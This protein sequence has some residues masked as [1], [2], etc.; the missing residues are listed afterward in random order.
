MMPM[1]REIT[2]RASIPQIM[3]AIRTGGDGM[4]VTFDVPE[5]DMPQA[6]HLVAMRSMVLTVTVKAGDEIEAKAKKERKEAKA[7]G[8]YGA[9]W[10]SLF[11]AGFIS[12]P[13]IQ[14]VIGL[15]RERGD[16][17]ELDDKAMLHAM[18]EVDSLSHVSPD[19]LV[20]FLNQGENETP[21]NLGTVQLMIEQAKKAL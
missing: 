16:F 8:R 11:R 21:H 3:S 17:Y 19:D 15:H 9:F 6:L 13:G 10:Q 7:K 4:R 18:F 12:H 14:A 1:F 20:T 2:F 5:T